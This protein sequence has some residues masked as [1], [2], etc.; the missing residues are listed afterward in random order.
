MQQKHVIFFDDASRGNPR[1]V[2]VGGVL[3]DPG[4]KKGTKF[5]SS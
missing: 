1:V 2:G 5:L 3:W 4:G